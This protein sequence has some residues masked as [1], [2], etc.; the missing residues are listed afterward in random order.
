MSG[1]HLFYYSK[2]MV[3]TVVADYIGKPGLGHGLL[4][5][6]S[7]NMKKAINQITF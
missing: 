5:P 3:K 1:Q 7:V 6:P 4:A 2:A